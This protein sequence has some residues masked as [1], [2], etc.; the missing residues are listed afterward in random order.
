MRYFEQLSEEPNLAQEKFRY[1]LAL[2]LLQKRRL[3]I[4]GSRQDGE[5]QYLQLSG[6]RGEGQFDVRDHQ[7]SED[8]ILHLQ[9]DLNAHLATEWT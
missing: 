2:L 7:L 3:K 4:E 6:S 9:N 5:I 8:E 1:V